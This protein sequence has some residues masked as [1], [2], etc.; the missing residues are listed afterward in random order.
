[1]EIILNDFPKE[2]QVLLESMSITYIQQA[3]CCSDDDAIQEI[4]IDSPLK[5]RLRGLATIISKIGYI[6][7]FLVFFSYLF[8]LFYY[9]III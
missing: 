3:D 7:A 6:G 2:E 8:I 1:M 5:I 4:T 9:L